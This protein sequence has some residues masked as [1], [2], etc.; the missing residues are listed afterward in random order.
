MKR[1]NG[2]PGLVSVEKST[3]QPRGHQLVHNA[4][5]LVIWGAEA[6]L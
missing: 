1:R 5:S 6:E 4:H 3:I 2:G